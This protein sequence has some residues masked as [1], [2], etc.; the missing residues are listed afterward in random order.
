MYIVYTIH[1]YELQKQVEKRASDIVRTVKPDET[2][3]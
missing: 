1:L 3:H 2:G